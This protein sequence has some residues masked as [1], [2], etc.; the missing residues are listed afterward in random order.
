MKALTLETMFS[1][2]SVKKLQPLFDAL[3]QAPVNEKGERGGI[4]I[5]VFETR[6]CRAVFLPNGPAK[7]LQS[8]LSEIRKDIELVEVSEK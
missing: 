6:Y 2:E 7:K 8:A 3:N 4:F 5:E 1:V